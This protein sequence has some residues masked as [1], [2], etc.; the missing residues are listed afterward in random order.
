MTERPYLKPL[1]GRHAGRALRVT[2]KPISS[3]TIQDVVSLVIL[4]QV[5]LQRVRNIVSQSHTYTQND[6]CGSGSSCTTEPLKSSLLEGPKVRLYL[7]TSDG[8]RPVSLP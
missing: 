5:G 1:D 6:H 3:E 2:G 4:N 8:T 7:R